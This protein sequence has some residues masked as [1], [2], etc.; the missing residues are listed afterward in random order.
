[1]MK[2][3][4][5][6][7][8][9]LLILTVA[10]VAQ[11]P[12]VLN[13]SAT[14]ENCHCYTLT[15]EVEAQSGSIWNKNKIDL[16]QPFD[17]FFNVFLGCNDADG[18]D[19]IAF[20]LQPV[21]TSL[22]TTGEG[23]GF[24]NILPSAGVTIDTWQN[25]AQNDPSYDHIAIQANGDVDHTT[26]NNLAGP[27]QALANSDNI[28][29]CQWHVLEINWE[30]SVDSMIIKMDGI[31]RLSLQK[32]IV[33]DIFNDDPLVYWGFT[34][35]TGGAVNLQQMCTSLDAG[36]N[37]AA[38]TN[39][40]IGTPLTFVDSSVSFG[41]IAGWYW[42][43]GDGTTSTLQNPPAHTYAKPRIYKVTLNITG[44]DGCTSDTT[45]QEITV[46]SYPVADFTTKPSLACDNQDVV[47]TDATTLDV[48]TEN[49]WYWNFG[50]G[51]TS[52][53]QN[54][55]P[56]NYAAGE[57]T[58]QFYVKT[59]EGCAS[60]T[61]AKTFTVSEA[62]EIDFE[63]KDTCRNTP[64]DFLAENLSPSVTINEWYWDF[65][66]NSFSSDASLQHVFTDTG[67]YNVSLTAQAAN[68][69]ISDT[70]TKPV[71]M[72]GT[73]AYAGRDSTILQGY[74]YQLQASGGTYYS[75]SPSTGLNNP[76]VANPVATLDNDITYILTASTDKGCATTDTLNLRVIKG[77]EIYVP[78]AFT[79]NNDGLND[80][81]KIIPV[82]ISEISLFN[83][84]NRWGQV[85]YASKNAS[86]GWDGNL[87]GVPQPAGTYIWMVEGKTAT[88]SILKKR[89]TVVL[90][91]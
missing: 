59:A 46:G 33:A 7:A 51:A 72:Y 84:V 16:T 32:D 3:R 12:Y 52:S 17:Y 20:V 85:V 39:T 24:Q 76:N 38:H 13:G 70:V 1:M 89:G 86:S 71:I 49:Y 5:S 37:L 69:C 62:P 74:P 48:G 90:V 61:A 2:K 67:T 73:N 87:N 21:S 78:L 57:Y 68:G 77:P 65:D 55:L 15:M 30:P 35:A 14:Q 54:P 63:K 8:F 4:I 27:V 34:S 41:S 81:F 29:D 79:P 43:F 44:G 10:A 18:A 31:L 6:L 75:W 40:C 42:N 25:T 22:G 80:R 47:F 66:D 83:I 26:S 82:G 50:N 11:N 28:E 58:V 19:G 23:L 36:F 53:L 64:V 91:R 45:V 60:D 9:L 88:G 56:V